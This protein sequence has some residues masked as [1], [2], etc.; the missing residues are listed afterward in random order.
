MYSD[1]HYI[2]EIV[3]FG[4]VN[5]ECSYKILGYGFFFFLVHAVYFVSENF[6]YPT[7]FLI[8]ILPGASTKRSIVPN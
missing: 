4:I 6:T 2:L 3:S 1:W 5:C 7:C 8:V